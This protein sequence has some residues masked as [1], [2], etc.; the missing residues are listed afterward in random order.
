M[1][2]EFHSNFI[3][4]ALIGITILLAISCKP[5]KDKVVAPAYFA[6]L[7]TINTIKHYAGDS[8]KFALRKDEVEDPKFK[9]VDSL[10]YYTYLS[11]DSYFQ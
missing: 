11:R 10:F 4:S 5:I 9:L 7:D 6:H 1:F 8:L 2:S 3:P